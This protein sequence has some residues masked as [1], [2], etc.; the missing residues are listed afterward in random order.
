MSIENL[1]AWNILEG[2]SIRR[3]YN[4]ICTSKGSKRRFLK[5]V[6]MLIL[7]QSSLI[8]KLLQ[9]WV[10]WQHFLAKCKFY[11]QF[12]P[13]PFEGWYN[14][15]GWFMCSISALSSANGWCCSLLLQ[16]HWSQSDGS[17]A[18][19]GEGFAV[20]SACIGPFSQGGKLPCT[21]LV[22]CWYSWKWIGLYFFLYLNEKSCS[23]EASLAGIVRVRS[24]HIRSLWSWASH[25]WL[26]LHLIFL[27]RF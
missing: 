1:T 12:E 21:R 16:C 10:F 7:L 17:L 20:Y 2:V 27:D 18:L 8:Q 5:I 6:E 26:Q 9:V 3:K 25:A 4:F 11:F 15:E 13:L 24:W 19:G 22:P 14:F 23:A